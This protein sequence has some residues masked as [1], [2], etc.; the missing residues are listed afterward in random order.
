MYSLLTVRWKVV[1]SRQSEVADSVED[2]VTARVGRRERRWSVEVVEWRRQTTTYR[3]GG[4]SSVTGDRRGRRCGRRGHQRRRESVLD[5]R[6]RRRQQRAESQ[7]GR[8]RRRAGTAGHA[9]F[10]TAQV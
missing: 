8:M 5:L 3:G 1:D 10:Q 6:R 4:Q 9:C 7:P 2:E